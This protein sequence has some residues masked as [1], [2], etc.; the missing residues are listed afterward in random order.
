MQ[1]G[2]F[3]SSTPQGRALG[4]QL[5]RVF[6][7]AGAAPWVLTRLAANVMAA[8]ALAAVAAPAMAG[9][10]AAATDHSL[11]GASL[12]VHMVGVSLWVGG[13]VALA[14][15]A[16]TDRAALPVAAGR[17]SQLA[18]WSLVAVAA[19]GVA[20]AW[21]NLGGPGGLTSGY[22]VLVLAKAAALAGLAAF[23]RAHRRR[24]LPALARGDEG[25]HG[26]GR[27]GPFLRLAAGEVAV[28]M[29]TAGLAV[30]LAR[31]PSPVPHHLYGVAGLS[32][33]RLLVGFELPPEPNLARL[34]FLAR[35]DALVIAAVALAV[36]LYL[37]G[38]RV[39]RRRGDTW[40]LGRSAAWLGGLAV[41]VLVTCG[42]LG[43][44]AP[45][46]FSAHMVQH[47]VLNMLVPPLLVLGAP[48]TL[49]LR[50]LPAGTSGDPGPR[51]LLLALLHSRA[52]GVL[53]HPV[54]AAAIFVGSVYGLYFTPLFETT[55][56]SH[57]GHL[58]MQAH[59]VL[60]GMLF[61]W[62]LI[63]VDPGPRRPPYPLR[64]LLLFVVMAFHAFFSIAL[65]STT[66]VLAG[67]HYAA[68][69]RP[70]GGSALDDQKLG[71]GIGWAFGD[72]PIALV[73]AVLFV[74][75]VRADEREAR[76][77]DR[78]A[79]RAERAER[80]RA[81]DRKGP[82][83]AGD[84]GDPDDPALA[85]AAADDL[86]AY[87]QWLAALNQAEARRTATPTSESS[88][89]GSPESGTDARQTRRGDAGDPPGTPG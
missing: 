25:T 72:V 88:A 16:R 12:L 37:T 52:F 76:A 71:A 14:A 35:P 50:T 70:W 1:L 9:H 27:A 10:A 60:A 41:V 24:T 63:G 21:V 58:A 6:L 30:G 22:G 43:R 53:A 42:G 38:V 7:V 23:G 69:N 67:P 68:L 59:F 8:I 31:T 87:N 36:A 82:D 17:F 20:V 4:V 5:F 84:P 78:A 11:A 65:M 49:A 83:N 34:L 13:L 74:Q 55:M 18:G 26:A 32:P 51:A 75:W 44:Y 85:V 48:V 77:A 66:T 45:V 46:L 39:L 64:V 33:A 86:S 28:M 19:S 29:A 79:D 57:W 89:G 40:P 54:T 61:F 2:N 73:L 15:A 81:R 62:V 3:L 47:M 56:R 80:A